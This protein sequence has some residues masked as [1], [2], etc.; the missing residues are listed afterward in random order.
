MNSSV[1]TRVGDYTT[2]AATKRGGSV[3]ERK[4]EA[5]VEQRSE[6][7]CFRSPIQ[8]SSSR[9]VAPALL[10]TCAHGEDMCGALKDAIGVAGV[11]LAVAKDCR[12]LT[13]I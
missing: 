10:I 8:T 12:Q 6:H 4:C 2:S 1:M 7:R 13:R 9:E 5:V 3:R 11:W